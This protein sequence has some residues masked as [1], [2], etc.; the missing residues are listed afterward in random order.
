MHGGDQIGHILQI[1]FGSDRLL[2]VVGVGAVQP[3]LVGSVLDDALF[4]GRRDLPSVDA[5]SNAIL[6]AQMTE[7]SLLVG[8]GGVFPERPDTAVS[9][10][11]DEVVGHEADH[12]GSDHVEKRFDVRFLTAL[13]HGSFRFLCQDGYLLYSPTIIQRSPS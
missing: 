2:Q 11:A 1:A 9:V 7:D 6:L 12:R 8:A 3:V 10:A 4:F 13:R 5:Q